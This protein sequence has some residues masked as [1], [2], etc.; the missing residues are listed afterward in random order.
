MIDLKESAPHLDPS[1]PQ[2]RKWASLLY[3]GGYSPGR[4][5]NKTTR[6]LNPPWGSDQSIWPTITSIAHRVGTQYL[7][8]TDGGNYD[9]KIMAYVYGLDTKGTGVPKGKH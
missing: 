6:T 5:Y 2:T 4:F 7:D 1:L 9:K 8:P 3:G